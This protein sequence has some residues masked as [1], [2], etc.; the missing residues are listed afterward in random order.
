LAVAQVRQLQ[1]ALADQPLVTADGVHPVFNALQKA[2]Q[3]AR[4]LAVEL[5]LTVVSRTRSYQGKSAGERE[6]D[7]QRLAR[8]LTERFLWPWRSP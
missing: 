5:G 2:M 1:A 8:R 6:W 4:L 7:E 3:S